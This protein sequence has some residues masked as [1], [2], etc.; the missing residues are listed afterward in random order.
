LTLNRAGARVKRMTADRGEADF[1]RSK[2]NF[3]QKQ[4]PEFLKVSHLFRQAVTQ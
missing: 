4:I 3:R 1:R 2:T